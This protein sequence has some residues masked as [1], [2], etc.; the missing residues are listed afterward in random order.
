VVGACGGDARS[1]DP[2]SLKTY[3]SILSE[4]VEYWKTKQEHDLVVVFPPEYRASI[5]ELMTE[6]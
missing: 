4:S 2:P 1:E 3:L 6:R 5:R